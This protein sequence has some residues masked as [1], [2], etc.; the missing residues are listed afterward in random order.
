VAGDPGSTAANCVGA[1]GTAISLGLTWAVLSE[2]WRLRNEGDRAQCAIAITFLTAFLPILTMYVA[3]DTLA[4]DRAT[5]PDFTVQVLILVVLAGFQ[6]RGFMEAFRP[7]SPDVLLVLGAALVLL[8]EWRFLPSVASGVLSLPES[9][10]ARTLR[11]AKAL[12]REGL[13]WAVPASGTPAPRPSCRKAPC[14]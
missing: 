5:L 11:L 7:T 14:G 10:S 3:F 12:Q 2:L 8:P 4:A 9:R 6:F 13:R 1:F